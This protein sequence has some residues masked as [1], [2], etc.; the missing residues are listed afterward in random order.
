MAGVALVTGKR[1]RPRITS[2]CTVLSDWEVVEAY[3]RWDGTYAGAERLAGFYGVSFRTLLR[4]FER[5]RQRWEEMN[6]GKT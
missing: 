5:M 4:S 1:G 3:E 6:A 2:L